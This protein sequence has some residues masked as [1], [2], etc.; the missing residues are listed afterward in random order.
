MTWHALERLKQR[1]NLDLNFDDLNIISKNIASLGIHISKEPDRPVYVS[2]IE[3]KNL[4]LKLVWCPNKCGSVSIIT[5][6][7][8]DVEEYNNLTQIPKPVEYYICRINN[9][10]GKVG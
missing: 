3:Y 6:L 7:P 2:Y 9:T 1:Y 10:L 4:P 8:L 5:A